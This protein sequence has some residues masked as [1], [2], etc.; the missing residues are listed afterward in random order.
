MGEG[1]EQIAGQFEV[2]RAQQFTNAC[3][4]RVQ[5]IAQGLQ[6]IDFHARY[7]VM[8]A[9]LA[10]QQ[11]PALF[12][13]FANGRRAQGQPGVVQRV[14][15]PGMGAHFGS[16][17]ARIDLAARK[18]QRARGEI[19]LVMAHHHQHLQVA[20]V[21]PD[22]ENCGGGCGNGGTGRCCHEREPFLCGYRNLRLAA[23]IQGAAP[24]RPVPLPLS[25]SHAML[26]G[27]KPI[28]GRFAVEAQE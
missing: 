7:E 20:L 26:N 8:G 10:G 21:L 22:E 1:H 17:I 5:T 12:E 11:N 19:D 3:L 4:T 28:P 27:G 24:R 6:R 23:C 2:C 25:G 9:A 14:R 13:G 16:I 18:N 15:T